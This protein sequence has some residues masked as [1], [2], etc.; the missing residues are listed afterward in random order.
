MNLLKF[1]SVPFM[2]LLQFF[3]FSFD[4]SEC[5]Y[6]IQCHLR[7]AHIHVISES[8]GRSN[9]NGQ[10]NKQK[11]SVK[12]FRSFSVHWCTVFYS[13]FVCAYHWAHISALIF[14]LSRAHL[15]HKHS[16]IEIVNSMNGN[17]KH[18]C[19]WCSTTIAMHRNVVI[20]IV[21][22]LFYWATVHE[23]G[24]REREWISFY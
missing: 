18:W 16:H 6:S 2:Q 13:S 12:E 17:R 3:F 1:V 7:T 4:Q 15:F 10:T 14:T 8:A 5:I 23:T 22:I 19:A 24:K 9:G 20:G 11:K 21:N